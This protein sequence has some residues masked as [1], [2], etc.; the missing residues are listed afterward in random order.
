MKDYYVYILST[1]FHKM[2]YI[3]VTNN[4]ERRMYEHKNK[5]IEWF[6]KKYT[7]DKLVYYETCHSIDD[8][9]QRE[10]QL[11]WFLRSKKNRLISA[12]NLDWKDLSADW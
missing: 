3:W 12:D 5:L 10:K 11:K 8:A 7:I 4:L 9:I 2:L 1:K 6:T